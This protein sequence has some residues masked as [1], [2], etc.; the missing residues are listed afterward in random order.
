MFSSGAWA[1]SK[2]MQTLGRTRFL[3]II[4]LSPSAPRGY[5]L[6]KQF[7]VLRGVS[8]LLRV[9]SFK[10]S[11]HPLRSGPRRTISLLMNSKSTD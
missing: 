1:S 9:S 8:L 11:L 5:P 3:A 4:G 10:E 6:T 2:L 7:K